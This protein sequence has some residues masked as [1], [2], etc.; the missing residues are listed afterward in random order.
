MK[1]DQKFT[2][3]YWVYYCNST[4]SHLLRT[5]AKG[6]SISSDYFR[7]LYP[8]TME[9]AYDDESLSVQQ[10]LISVKWLESID[11]AHHRNHAYW[12]LHPTDTDDILVDS[13]QRLKKIV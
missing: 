9:A 11:D 4:S 12:V 5:C 1:R 3:K 7:A 10:L 6:A 8:F 13:W 2:P